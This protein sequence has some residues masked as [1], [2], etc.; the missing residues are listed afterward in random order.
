M[1][2]TRRELILSGLSVAAGSLA[3][4]RVGHA[5]EAGRTSEAGHAHGARAPAIGADQALQKLIEGNRR[6]V[7][8]KPRHPHCTAA[9]RAEIAHGQHPFA[10]VLG[11][12]DSRVPPEI[13]FDEGL[14][15][16]FVVRQA[17]H[18]ADDDSL[19]SI[20]YAVGHLGVPLVVVLGHER[21]G[22]VQAAVSAIVSDDPVPG[23]VLRLIDDIGPAVLATKGQPGDPVDNAVRANV[24]LVTEKLR[25]SFPVLRSLVRSGRVRIVPAYYD[26][27]SGEVQWLPES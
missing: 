25:Q 5:K 23:H 16:L 21:C 20:E 12:A 2:M 11:C 9:W 19:A 15:D 24:R 3:L 4:G 27:D 6:F 7:S 18:V 26:L 1:S 13:L 14:G 17:G 10:V 22:A 8:G